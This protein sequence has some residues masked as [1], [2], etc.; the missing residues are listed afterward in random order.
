MVER[1]PRGRRRGARR[2]HR[3]RCWRRIDI[4]LSVL[5]ASCLLF[6]SAVAAAASTAMAAPAVD[7]PEALIETDA[8]EPRWPDTASTDWIQLTSGEWLRGTVDRIRDGSLEFDS[9]ELDNLTL[10]FSDVYAVVPGR[11]QTLLFDGRKTVT[12]QVA[13]RGEVLRVRTQSGILTF[14]RDKIVGMVPGRPREAN[15]WS[16]KV[17]AGLSVQSGNT[18]QKDF[19]ALTSLMRETA[20]TRATAQYNGAISSANGASTANN[21]RVNVKGDLFLTRRFYVTL[22]SFE[23]YTDFFQ[24]IDLR[25]VPAAGIGYALVDTGRF[26]IDVELAV[27]ATYTRDVTPPPLTTVRDRTIGSIIFRT[28]FD[29]DIT[30]R[31]EW[32]GEFKVQLGVPETAQTFYHA[33]TTASIDIWGNLDFDTTFVWDRNQAPAQRSDGTQPVQ[34]DFRLTFGL[35]WDF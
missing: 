14:E 33:L 26:D 4:P 7:P 29:S 1:E 27:G 2:T 8:F 17:S 11:T 35:G 3:A 30:E 21:H 12:G 25:L 22:L 18:N 16:G 13:I 31:I 24:N 20:L 5:L 9:E 28:T 34:N 10:D 19:T 6:D 15:Y 23:Y 32:N